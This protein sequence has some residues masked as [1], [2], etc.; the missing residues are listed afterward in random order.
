LVQVPQASD[1]PPDFGVPAKVRRVSFVDLQ[2]I[3]D[4]R[5]DLVVAEVGRHIPFVTQRMYA[6]VNVPEG[7]ER[8]GHAHR[9]LEQVL[10]VLSGSLQLLVDDGERQERI[11]LQ[12]QS[13]A[14]YI[15]PMVWRELSCFAPG[16]VCM[17]L[18]SRVY[19]EADYIRDYQTFMREVP[20]EAHHRAPSQA[21][22]RR[23]Q[24]VDWKRSEAEP[25]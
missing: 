14:V 19:Q 23:P 25:R 8:G 10:V 15:R 21:S 16:T 20:T 7:S 17:V 13:R 9:A 22:D 11:H 2:K 18:A 3:T 1:I 6:L 12:E 24:L 4:R 5:G